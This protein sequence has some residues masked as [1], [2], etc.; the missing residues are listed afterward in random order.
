[1]ETDARSLSSWPDRE[2][3][4]AFKGGV[5]EAY[6]EMYRRYSDRISHVCRKMLASPEDAREATQETFLKAYQ[7]LPRFNGEYKLGAWLARIAS[8][9]CVDHIRR[10]TR[11]ARV[12]PLTEQHEGLHH[13]IGPEDVVVRDLPALHTLD[14][15]QPLHARALRLRN[16]HGLSHK[17]IAAQL[18]MS[19][20]QVKALLHRA[21]TSFKR[22]WENASGWVLAPIAGVRSFLHDGSKDASLGA[23]LP[24]WTQTATPLLAEK[25]AASAIVVAIA[26]SGAPSSTV[27][28]PRSDVDTASPQELALGDHPVVIRPGASAQPAKSEANK[29]LVAKVGLVIE[30]VKKAADEP[31][32]DDKKND[33]AGDDGD[34]TID[35]SDPNR[36]SGQVVKTVTKT[37]EDTLPDH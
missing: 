34:D 27:A 29:S 35:P 13:D 26:F 23:H 5:P 9:V 16:F 24:L 4:V 32:R 36:A 8:N 30:K 1:M 15:I 2:L 25:V 6:D 22:A 21:R 10:E 12:T 17:E 37:A 7:A 28:P 3:V 14:Q 19:P 33:G 20:M 31:R 18:G 11:T